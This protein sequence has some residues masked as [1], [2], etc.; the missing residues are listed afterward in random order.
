MKKFFF[1]PLSVI[2]AVVLLVVTLP[3]HGMVVASAIEVTPTAAAVTPPDA[4]DSQGVAVPISEVEA[5]RT[6]TSKTVLNNDGSYS[7]LGYPWQ[8]HFEDGNGGWQE[9]D[10]GL[11]DHGDF[12]LPRASDVGLAMPKALGGENRITLANGIY[13][14]AIGVPS[15]GLVIAPQKI[16]PEETTEPATEPTT[17]T[18]TEAESNTEATTEETMTDAPETT[19]EAPETATEEITAAPVTS[20]ETE[21]EI[22]EVE[23]ETYASPNEIEASAINVQSLPSEAVVLESENNT[24][25]D[26]ITVVENLMSSLVYPNAFP[27]ANLQYDILPGML[28]EY[29]I[30]NEKNGRYVYDFTLDLENLIA[31]QQDERTIHLNCAVSGDLQVVIEAPYAVDAAGEINEEALTLSIT[32]NVLT[33]IADANWMNAP[34]R[35][36]PVKLDPSYT[37]TPERKDI[38]TATVNSR[39]QRSNGLF[40]HLRVGKEEG[41]ILDGSTHRSLLQFDMPPMPNDAVVTWAEL[42]LVS[43][44]EVTDKNNIKIGAHRINEYWEDR[45]SWNNSRSIFD[46]SVLDIGHRRNPDDYPELKD[47]PSDQKDAFKSLFFFNVT[48]AVKSWHEEGTDNFGIMLKALNENADGV[49]AFLAPTGLVGNWFFHGIRP[50]VAVHYRNNVGLE[51]YWTYETVEMNRSGTAQVNQYSGGLTYVHPDASLD[52]ERM[53]VA[54]AHTYVSAREHFNASVWNMRFG[55][56]FRLNLI[57]EIQPP[58]YVEHEDPDGTKYQIYTYAVV[59]GTGAVQYYVSP[60][61]NNNKFINEDNK[62]ITM[63][64][65][66]GEMHITDALG[67][68]K[69]YI[70]GNGRY[71]LTA[72]EDANGNVTTIHYENG[73]IEYVQDTVGRKLE[74]K[75]END[76]LDRIKVPVDGNTVTGEATKWRELRFSYDLPNGSGLGLDALKSIKYFDE[77]NKEEGETQFLFELHAGLN[78]SES[79]G[80]HLSAV[81]NIAIDKDADGNDVRTPTYVVFDYE[82][83]VSQGRTGYCVTEIK[84]GLGSHTEGGRVSN[85]PDSTP[86]NSL[87]AR[88]S[89]W[90]YNIVWNMMFRPSWFNIDADGRWYFGNKRPE[91][92]FIEDEIKHNYTLT[93]IVQ[94]I[95]LTYS[96]GATK[97]EN[98][99]SPEQAMTYLFDFAGRTVGVQNNLGESAATSFE[100]NEGARNLPASS[101]DG[102]IVRNL[103]KDPSNELGGN[104]WTSPNA[105]LVHTGNENTFTYDRAWWTTVTG[106]AFAGE[107]SWSLDQGAIIEQTVNGLSPGTYTVSGYFKGDAAQLNILEKRTLLAD[108]V[109][110]SIETIAVDEWERFSITFEIKNKRNVTVS[111]QSSGDFVMVDAVQFEASGGASAFNFVSNSFFSNGADRWTVKDGSGTVSDNAYVLQGNPGGK[112]TLQQEFAMYGK[113]GQMVTFGANAKAMAV[114]SGTFNATAAFYFRRERI[115]GDIIREKDQYVQGNTYDFYVGEATVPFISDIRGYAQTAMESYSLAGDVTHVRL[116]INYHNQPEGKMHELTVYDAFMYLNAGG[117]NYSYKENSQKLESMNTGA[118]TMIFT[119]DTRAGR[120]ADIIKI[121][122]DRPDGTQEVTDITYDGDH[123]IAVTIDNKP[124]I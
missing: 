66:S 8:I 64:P 20:S 49:L 50:T 63:R 73:R 17:E 27:G 69:K 5:M 106:D 10:N 56:G 26:D 54:L 1:R 84:Q 97:I 28:K 87:W 47:L 119:H 24:P 98:S 25:S 31:V 88:F 35:A 2:L 70:P 42:V 94:E 72:I 124:I 110:D 71:Y 67:N 53:P 75:W 76:Y 85:K 33:L 78:P 15:A 79:F 40:G 58:T 48:A 36:Y 80:T 55:M 91:D 14:F 52:G 107:R 81:I 120:E 13:Q 74:L 113:E 4:D 95:D 122:I 41:F 60:D 111:I 21:A 30:V 29:V 117:S 65:V 68:T 19:T 62:E 103:L 77:N 3:L 7:S 39:W 118:G 59:D 96:P 116:F 43:K 112:S 22:H 123:N 99:L 57:E 6:A 18:P 102:R 101:A 44:D 90:V 38:K 83:R 100:D 82:P 86:N 37:Y 16:I 121:T 51:D 9:Y 61:R 34:E 108:L 11:V 12:Y 45:V 93:E 109:I 105:T 114:S 89:R 46:A 115:T 23:L 92:E 32:G 104:N